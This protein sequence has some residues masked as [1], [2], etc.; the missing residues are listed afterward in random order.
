M[1]RVDRITTWHYF[2][3]DGDYFFYQPDWIGS[4]GVQNKTVF[5]S[6]NDTYFQHCVYA[7]Y[8]SFFRFTTLVYV[9]LRC[10]CIPT[11]WV[12]PW[13]VVPQ[14]STRVYCNI[15]SDVIFFDKFLYYIHGSFS[16]IM[17][18]LVSC[19]IKKGLGSCEKM[20]KAVLKLPMKLNVRVMPLSYERAK[21]ELKK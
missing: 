7:H 19:N 13:K 8:P 1:D 5:R 11:P 10:F 14:C 9:L 15:N 3:L 6:S 17:L 16:F 4:N 12:W 21:V 2:F 20:P 18:L